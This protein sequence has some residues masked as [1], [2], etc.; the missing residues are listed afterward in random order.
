MGSALSKFNSSRSEQ[1]HPDIIVFQSGG[2]QIPDSLSSINQNGPETSDTVHSDSNLNTFTS[3]IT[4]F[5][6]RSPTKRSIVHETTTSSIFS[7][8]LRSFSAFQSKTTKTPPASP[9]VPAS[10]G[11]TPIIVRD[12]NSENQNWKDIQLKNDPSLLNIAGIKGSPSLP[13]PKYRKK[14][15]PLQ[16]ALGR[17]SISSDSESIASVG[18]SN[19]IVDSLKE[20][21]YAFS[22]I[23]P[24]SR[25][26]LASR[27]SSSGSTFSERLGLLNGSST[28]LQLE[29]NSM[30]R[31]PSLQPAKL[32][33]SLL[34]SKSQVP[35]SPP[36]SRFRPGDSLPLVAADLHIMSIPLWLRKIV[37]MSADKRA[38]HLTNLYRQIESSESV[39]LQSSNIDTPATPSFHQ[40]SSSSSLMFMWNTSDSNISSGSINSPMSS[41][42][43]H[44][45]RTV[46]N[47]QINASR[48]RYQDIVPFDY[49]RVRL[50]SS[51][52]H[53]DYINASFVGDFPGCKTYIASQA[54]LESTL[55][56]FWQMIWD[57]KTPLIVMLT[58]LEEHGRLKSAQ[59][60]PPSIGNQKSYGDIV[61]SFEDEERVPSQTMVIVR[62]FTVSRNY[63]ARKIVQVQYEG[64][65]DHSSSNARSVLTVIDMANNLLRSSVLSVRRHLYFNQLENEE[66]LNQFLPDE[67]GQEV[68]RNVPSPPP[69]PDLLSSPLV[70]PMVIHCSA[71]CGRTGTFIAIDTCLTVLDRLLLFRK[72]DK[73]TKE[74]DDQDEICDEVRSSIIFDNDG[75]RIVLNENKTVSPLPPTAPASLASGIRQYLEGL[76]FDHD[77]IV[78]IVGLLR[79]QRVSSVQT[80]EQFSFVYEVVLARLVEWNAGG[81]YL[82]WGDDWNS[83]MNAISEHEDESETVK[84]SP[85]TPRA[86][87][88]NLAIMEPFKIGSKISLKTKLGIS[89][90]SKPIENTKSKP[91]LSSLMNIMRE[92]DPPPT[93][94][95][96]RTFDFELATALLKV[97]MEDMIEIE[98][99]LPNEKHVNESETSLPLKET[100]TQQDVELSIREILVPISKSPENKEDL[101]L[102]FAETKIEQLKLEAMTP[103]S[104]ESN[105]MQ[106]LEAV[107]ETSYN[108]EM[109]LQIF[110]EKTH[111]TPVTDQLTL[112]EEEITVSASQINA[113]DL[114]ILTVSLEEG[115]MSK[116]TI[117]VNLNENRLSLNNT[118]ILNAT[119]Y[120][121]STGTKPLSPKSPASAH[122]TNSKIQHSPCAEESVFEAQLKAAIARMTL[123][124][125]G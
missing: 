33:L 81:R 124:G 86:N 52:A 53:S 66:R 46:A 80:L 26:S 8:T 63:E 40:S 10:R 74:N 84:S 3:N 50:D 102:S 9:M 112:F 73:T 111:S 12:I 36:S 51:N 35:D 57:R 68:S 15:V 23:K 90:S 14:S 125:T 93:P 109:D 122:S 97:K 72:S 100:A 67:D 85:T 22:S 62:E 123:E 103:N 38:Q 107:T 117:T 39:R 89:E 7:T 34:K 87:K 119:N 60:W 76:E 92:T 42:L 56:D 19:R 20:D 121:W 6:K 44:F 58:P 120:R 25:G 105:D 69:T 28:S 118:E 99:T 70:G 30:S 11:L 61:V 94:S 96:G 16:T 104:E 114:K 48:N 27:R 41:N 78:T 110:E 4:N 54:P 55:A 101:N 64:W 17:K 77:L 47:H 5:L 83:E 79:E 115:S 21:S 45:S 31:T 13:V 24:L 49:N 95:E 59:Y 116:S 1:S 108:N 32:D 29:S 2:P 113:T 37:K 18:I 106:I 75:L 71:G 65:E 43:P 82:A 98:V 91:K 88:E